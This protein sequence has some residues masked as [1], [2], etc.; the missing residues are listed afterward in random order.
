MAQSDP[1]ADLLTGIRNALQ[2]GKSFVD[3]YSSNIKLRIVQILEEQGY[4]EKHIVDSEKRKMRI[5]LKYTKGRKPVLRGLKRISS[6]GLRKYTT[7][8]K[9][10]FFFGLF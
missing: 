10:P 5:F 3:V 2:A 9:I 1:I 4:I 7:Y 8:K 6:P